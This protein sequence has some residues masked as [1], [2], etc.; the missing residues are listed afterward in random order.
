MRVLSS[1]PMPVKSTHLS[2]TKHGGQVCSPLAPLVPSHERG[3][4]IPGSVI[5]QLFS[6]R[7]SLS[8]YPIGNCIDN[9]IKILLHF[10]FGE[11][12][13]P[14]EARTVPSVRLVV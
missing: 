4:L 8:L 11:P 6:L 13:S 12:K 2:A 1:F 5:V 9:T 7:H 14:I 10:L 3:R